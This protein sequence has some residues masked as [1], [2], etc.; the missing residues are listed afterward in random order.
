MCYACVH[1]CPLVE[2]ESIAV[3]VHDFGVLMM[4][5]FLRIVRQCGL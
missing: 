2:L 4:H 5:C 3:L 1:V